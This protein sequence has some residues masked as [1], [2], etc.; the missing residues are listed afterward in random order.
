M[1]IYSLAVGVCCKA[2]ALAASAFA[3]NTYVSAINLHQGSA[4]DLNPYNRKCAHRAP[5]RPPHL[6]SGADYATLCCRCASCRSLSPE[7]AIFLAGTGRAGPYLYESNTVS[8]GSVRRG[9]NTR[10][11]SL[12]DFYFQWKIEYK[13]GVIGNNSKKVVYI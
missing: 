1:Q 10:R 3:T 8:C 13:S 4:A 11:D 7:N 2:S 5:L 9:V 6:W 12:T